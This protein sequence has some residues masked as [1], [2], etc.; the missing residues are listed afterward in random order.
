MSHTF[1]FFP[2]ENMQYIFMTPMGS[3]P[4][5]NPK[6]GNNFGEFVCHRKDIT[7]MMSNIETGVFESFIF[8]LLSTMYIFGNLN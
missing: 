8:R 5:A 4:Y 2:L 7:K 6:F 1:T 3:I